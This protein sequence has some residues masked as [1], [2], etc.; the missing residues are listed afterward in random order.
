V[1]SFEYIILKIKIKNKKRVGGGLAWH[2]G[3]LLGIGCH[4][5]RRRVGGWKVM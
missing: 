5:M 3:I 4:C 2:G 1:F